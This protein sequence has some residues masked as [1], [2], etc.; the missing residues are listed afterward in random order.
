MKTL[1]KKEKQNII[2]VNIV[3][4][5]LLL[6]FFTKCCPI[7]PYDAD[8]WIYMGQIRIPVPMWKGWNPCKV[9]P[10]VMMSMCG[11]IGAYVVY[12]LVGDYFLSITITAASILTIF[13]VTLC[14][15][16]MWFINRRFRFSIN[17]SLAFEVF[18]LIS[19][20]VIFRNRG[21]STYMFFAEN[22]NCIFNYTVPG[23]VNGIAVLYMMGYEDFAKAYGG[24]SIVKKI[25]FIFLI[26]MAVF[27]NIFHSETIA[28]YCGVILLNGLLIQLKE[29]SWNFK[30]YVKRYRIYLCIV[31]IWLCALV[32]EMSGGRAEVVSS[33]KQLDFLLS[34]KQLYA[35]IQ[36]IAVPFKIVLGLVLIGILLCFLDK[37]RKIRELQNLYIS[38]IANAG[39]VTVYVIILGSAVAY[40]SR[41]EASWNIWFYVILIT[42]IGVASFVSY[43]PK[44]KLFVLPVLLA[45][46]VLAIYPDGRYKISTLG[47][48]DYATC[49]NTGKYVMEQIVEADQNGEKAV[50]VHAPIYTDAKLEWAF[51]GN[52]AYVVMETLYNHGMI[53]N[54][55]DVTTISDPLLLD[56]LKVI[57]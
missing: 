29:K 13:I 17:L 21:T 51:K 31:G 32:F 12:P 19:N 39:L 55:L 49:V 2:I 11:Y 46:F 41:V 33:G 25:A 7:V 23:I 56:E 9:L 27:S 3:I 47:N 48:T 16:F 28:I 38:V 1:S 36:A 34:M 53:K 10:E 20:Y 44:T 22:M 45:W 24:F 50:E 26:Y 5:I 18:F 43:V 6:F 52:F 8:D 57:K 30:V 40:V 42:M 37:K 15:C 54:K 35:M 14:L 4:G